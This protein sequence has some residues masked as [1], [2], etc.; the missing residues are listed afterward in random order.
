MI[1]GVRPEQSSFIFPCTLDV[2]D[3]TAPPR[4]G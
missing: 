4:R 1:D 3:S 2:R